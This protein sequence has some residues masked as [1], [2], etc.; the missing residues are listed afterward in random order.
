MTPDEEKTLTQP[1]GIMDQAL[2]AN[3][4]GMDALITAWKQK[5]ATAPAGTVAKPDDT[6]K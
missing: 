4:S 6:Q 1:G 2:W 5:L 3:R